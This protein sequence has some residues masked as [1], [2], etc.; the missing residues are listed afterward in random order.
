[1]SSIGSSIGCLNKCV[2]RY[3]ITHI[4][5]TYTGCV[6]KTPERY[7]D[8]MTTVRYFWTI[9]VRLIEEIFWHV[10][11]KFYCQILKTSKVMKFLRNIS[12]FQINQAYKTGICSRNINP[13]YRSQQLR[14]NWKSCLKT[15]LEQVSTKVH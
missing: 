2:L 1:M 11:T 9:F 14:Q 6:K 15:Y 12:K 5:L 13:T 3:T 8:I 4:F 10:S 7:F